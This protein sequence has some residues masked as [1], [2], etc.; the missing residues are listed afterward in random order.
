MYKNKDSIINTLTIKNTKEVSTIYNEDQEDYIHSS[1]TCSGGGVFNKGVCIGMQEKMNSGLLLYD[2]ENF[3][4]FS[5]KFG[6]VLLSNNNEYRELEI[7][8]IKNNTLQ[9]I[10]PGNTNNIENKKITLNIYIKDNP[11][12]HIIIP[13]NINELFLF[14]FNIQYIINDETMISKLNIIFI[15]KSNKNIKINHIGNNLYFKKENKIINID[16]NMNNIIKYDIDII[17]NEYILISSEKFTN[18]N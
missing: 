18:N 6:L 4:G 5:D 11:N 7:E 1:L 3:Y 14:E 15:N 16:E 8:E 9:P 2:N 12:F 13:N 10:Q 17:S